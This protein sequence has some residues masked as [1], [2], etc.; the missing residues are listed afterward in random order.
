V[1]FKRRGFEAM[2]ASAVLSCRISKKF[3]TFKNDV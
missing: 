1:T 2:V 3:V